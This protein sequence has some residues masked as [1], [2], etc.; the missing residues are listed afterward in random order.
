MAFP[1]QKWESGKQEIGEQAPFCLCFIPLS[2]LYFHNVKIGVKSP[3]EL[4]FAAITKEIKMIKSM[5]HCT[6]LNCNS[7]WKCN[8]QIL[9]SGI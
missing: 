3:K 7:Y 1:L 6:S 2:V 4:P 9:I 5:S 8:Y